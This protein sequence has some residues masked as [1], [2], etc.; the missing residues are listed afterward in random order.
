MFLIIQWVQSIELVHNTKVGYTIAIRLSSAVI[1]WV[2][3]ILS[4]SKNN[5]RAKLYDNDRLYIEPRL[6]K[7][8]FKRPDN[9]SLPFQWKQ[10]RFVHNC[11]SAWQLAR[12]IGQNGILWVSGWAGDNNPTYNRRAVLLTPDKQ[13]YNEEYHDNRVARNIWHWHEWWAARTSK[14]SHP[15]FFVHELL[16]MIRQFPGQKSIEKGLVQTGP[17]TG[18]LAK[19]SAA[20]QRAIIAELKA[21]NGE[22]R[23]IIGK[24][25]LHGRSGRL[26][27]KNAYDESMIYSRVLPLMVE[28][29]AIKEARTVFEGEKID[30]HLSLQSMWE[31]IIGH[32]TL[33]AGAFLDEYVNEKR[34]HRR[35]A[36]IVLD[37]TIDRLD[38]YDSKQLASLLGAAVYRNR[39][40]Q[41]KKL[42]M[43]DYENNEVFCANL[44]S[45]ALYFNH[46]ATVSLLIKNNIPPLDQQMRTLVNNKDNLDVSE[47]RL[48]S[49]CI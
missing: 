26:F 38:E 49:Q 23:R 11:D 21:K 46:W 37:Y 27:D 28:N 40:Q 3:I 25:C 20:A 5:S 19:K 16:T 39:T 17:I 30:P 6:Y 44:Y 31:N 36:E 45:I 4:W 15:R 10:A 14:L 43:T 47:S 42:L 41:V 13:E 12:P 32:H 2:V 7:N 29:G 33:I 35:L 34:Y 48:V 24:C 18:A 22:A 1:Y 9:C 8:G